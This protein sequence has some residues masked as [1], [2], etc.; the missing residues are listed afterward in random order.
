[1]PSGLTRS[2]LPLCPGAARPPLQPQTGTE[3]GRERARARGGAFLAAIPIA[4]PR[5]GGGASSLREPRNRQQVGVRRVSDVGGRGPVV[6]VAYRQC[7]PLPPLHRLIGRRVHSPETTS[8]HPWKKHLPHPP[9]PVSQLNTQT[10]GWVGSPAH[11]VD[12]HAHNCFDL[13]L[14]H[15]FFYCF[16]WLVLPHAPPSESEGK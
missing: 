14:Q 1:M 5:D 8:P 10:A 11:P 16:I 15:L 2:P 13:S 7:S 3:T 12:N 4:R 6:G 9:Q